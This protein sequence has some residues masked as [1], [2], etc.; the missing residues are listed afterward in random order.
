MEYHHR[1][2]SPPPS[3]DDVVIIQMNAA[4]IAA[5][6]EWSSTNE[7]DDAAAG[8]GGGLTRRTFSQ[9]YKMK[10]RMPLVNTQSIS[11]DFM[12]HSWCSSPPFVD[13]FDLRFVVDVIDRSV[14]WDLGKKLQEFTWRQVAL[15]S[16][17]SLGV[18]YGDLGT[19]PLYVFSS[20]SLDDPGEADF[21]GILS[22]ILWTF[23]MICL[24]K[25]V[26]IVL[27]ADDH[28]EGIYLHYTLCSRK[29]ICFGQ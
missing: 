13:R 2:H 28:G 22:I 23:T 27:K 3:D 5:V 4:A 17:Q 26:F 1:P 21:V 12:R 16:F 20:I 8:K 7:V 18:V 10:H 19:S 29:G 14:D 15:L 24:V 25:Y 11:A 6:D 9:A